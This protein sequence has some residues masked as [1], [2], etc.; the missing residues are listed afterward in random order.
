MRGSCC[1]PT[2]TSDAS[3]ETACVACWMGFRP[4]DSGPF[5]C[6]SERDARRLKAGSADCSDRW[7]GRLRPVPFALAKVT[8]NAWRV[9]SASEGWCGRG[10]S[11]PYGIATASPSSWC[12][13]QFRHFRVRV[14]AALGFANTCQRRRFP[15]QRRTVSIFQRSGRNN[16]LG[17]R[18]KTSRAL[19]FRSPRARRF[20]R[21]RRR[22]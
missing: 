13:C 1:M 7:C 15:E 12:V 11:N 17:T 5:R 21:V 2:G 6:T 4:R 14:I 10:D 20:Q 8:R 22:I 19:D 3:S 18:E 16:R 9:A